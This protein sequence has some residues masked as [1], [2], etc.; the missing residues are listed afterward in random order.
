M[1][2]M[3]LLSVRWDVTTNNTNRTNPP[4]SI[5]IHY[6]QCQLNL[7]K[8]EKLTPKDIPLFWNSCNCPHCKFPFSSFSFT[9]QLW[10][11][12]N[13]SASL[14]V[15]QVI[16]KQELN[17][18]QAVWHHGWFILPKT[19]LS[20]KESIKCWVRIKADFKGDSVLLQ[21]QRATWWK[22]PRQHIALLN[23]LSRKNGDEHVTYGQC[24]YS[25]YFP[26]TLLNKDAYMLMFKEGDFEEEMAP[27][28]YLKGAS[29]QRS[30]VLWS[31]RK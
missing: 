17:P 30:I 21:R 22:Q 7:L 1:K 29:L 24:V 19:K 28:K 16:L 23:T 18:N 5:N 25:K 26:D 9:F 10:I 15:Y 13:I 6:E 4:V 2:Q 11:C 20:S 8:E 14:H 12:Q 31:T 3:C 27:S